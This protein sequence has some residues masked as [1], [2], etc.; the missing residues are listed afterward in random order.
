MI[1]VQVWTVSKR[2]TEEKENINDFQPSGQQKR[3]Q[4]WSMLCQENIFNG[5]EFTEGCLIKLLIFRDYIPDHTGALINN[6]NTND[7]TII[8]DWMEWPFGSRTQC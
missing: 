6:E 8:R 4:D 2:S 1:N 5:L 3:R 7:D